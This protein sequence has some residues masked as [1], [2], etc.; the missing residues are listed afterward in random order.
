MVKVLVVDDQPTYRRAMVDVVAAAEGFVVAG[1]ADSGEAALAAA[2]LDPPDLVLMDKRMP[3]IDGYEAARRL[4][5]R[6][7]GRPVV[8]IVSVEDPSQSKARAAGAAAAVKKHELLPDLLLELWKQHR[9][10][11]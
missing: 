9:P 11:E 10:T 6:H 1:E 7:H 2:D 3:G 4:V 5:E 8:V